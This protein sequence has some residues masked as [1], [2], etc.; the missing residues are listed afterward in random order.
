VY[1][2]VIADAAAEQ[3]TFH[4]CVAHPALRGTPDGGAVRHAQ[5]PW[6]P[7]SSG[8][9]N[10]QTTSSFFFRPPPG[11]HR[12]VT[13][14]NPIQAKQV[15]PTRKTGNISDKRKHVFTSAVHVWQAEMA[16]AGPK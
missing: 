14:D 4:V 16:F 15:Q 5:R 7:S 12:N 8:S 3:A 10:D 11:D 2:A 13:D 9:T 6:T 1:V